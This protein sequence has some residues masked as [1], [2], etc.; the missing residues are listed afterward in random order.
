MPHTCQRC[1]KIFRQ[2]GHLLQHMERKRPCTVVVTETP[3]EKSTDKPITID[4]YCEKSREELIA[5]CK[6]RKIKG[7]SGK[8]KL[9]IYA[10]L[11]GF[12]ETPAPK[13][14]S[15]KKSAK[16]PRTLKPL[17]KWS[18]GKSDEIPQF[19]K[20]IPKTFDTYL[21]PFIGGGSLFFHLNPQKAVITD[22][23]TEL[24]DFY[25]SIQKGHA[26]DIHTFMKEHEN[27][28]SVYYDVRDKMKVTNALDN[29]KRF[30]YL[31]KTC[32]RGM[33][34][35]NKQGKFN[36]PFGKYATVNFQDL[37]NEAYTTLLQRTEIF[38][39]GFEYVFENYNNV[40]N[41]MFLDPPYDSEFTDY[42]YCEFGKEEHRKLAKHFKETKIK[43]LMVIGK[44]DFI[45]ELYRDYIVE[46][47]DKKYKFKLYGGR[48][49]DEIN[50]KHLIIK[51]Y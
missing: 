8:K 21:E 16:E 26:A 5:L 30:Y 7:Y 9:E 15:K 13:T 36:I 29:A 1:K 11:R 25:T 47:Y 35:Y 18:G 22:V 46:E 38:A 27:S 2:K 44:T 40:N 41:F 10:L 28:E 39:K 3:E 32:F 33:L 50:T 17:V 19:I 23:H 42:G 24:I 34:R 4:D 49:G 20:H 31:R 51:N 43:C 48:I 6:E 45:T 12:T 14:V 37:Q